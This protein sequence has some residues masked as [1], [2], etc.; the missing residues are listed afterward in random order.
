[1]LTLYYSPGA[2]SLAAHI[3][4]EE[5]GAAFE[6]KRVTIVKGEH[7]TPD[8]LALNPHARVPT[9]TDGD[10]VLTES[11]AILSYL[12]HRFADAGLLE[13]D[14]LEHLG[15]TQELLNFFSSSVH[16]AFAQVWRA[17]RFADSE[18]AQA[19]I[20]AC[21]R[22]AVEKYFT[23]LEALAQDGAW[24]VADR[25]SIADPYMLVFYRWGWRIGLD[26]GRY[27]G[28]TR[29]K[30]KMLARPAVQRAVAREEIDFP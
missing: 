2:C 3:V 27:P 26:M 6:A 8:Y 24:I 14:N 1:M 7:Q 9:L 10:Y 23:E 17:A 20:V 22:T 11:P 5:A 25:Y 19:E 13:L 15:R 30:E 28:W 29:H 4:L 18:S 21:G 12:G 16:I